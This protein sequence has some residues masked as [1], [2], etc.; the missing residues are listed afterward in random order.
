MTTELTMLHKEI[1][2][3]IN[4]LDD[5]AGEIKSQFDNFMENISFKNENV[6]KF[7]QG[8]V[9]TLDKQD[10]DADIFWFVKQLTNPECPYWEL[11]VGRKATFNP[12]N[13][14]RYHY[15]TD[16]Y[17]FYV[18]LEIEVD[19]NNVVTNISFNHY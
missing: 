5:L 2:A 18:E 9:K 4:K 6:E 3:K 12:G 8:I 11:E 15:R 1:A 19:D 10:S 16:G 13:E 17:V 14:W 7:Y